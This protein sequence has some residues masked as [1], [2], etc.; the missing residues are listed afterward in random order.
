MPFPPKLIPGQSFLKGFHLHAQ[1]PSEHT[2]LTS[3]E[4]EVSVSTTSRDMNNG[5][6]KSYRFLQGSLLSPKQE[7]VVLH[8][9]D[10]R[11]WARQLF[12]KPP[13]LVGFVSI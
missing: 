11:H 8:L 4:K 3:Q 10:T 6:M 5:E 13:V 1:V 12:L 2:A 9:M 7:T